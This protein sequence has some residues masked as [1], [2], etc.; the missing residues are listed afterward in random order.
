M[1]IHSSTL[2]WEIPR[3][4]E[5]GGLQSLLLSTREPL[6]SN[7]SCFVSMYVSSDN[8]S[9]SVRQAP[10]LGSWKGSPFWE[11]CDW[12]ARTP[13]RVRLSLGLHQNSQPGVALSPSLSCYSKR[14][15]LWLGFHRAKEK[16]ATGCQLL[17][18]HILLEQHRVLP[19]S[20][21]SGWPFL[22]GQ[23]QEGNWFPPS[24]PII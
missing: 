9:P 20:Y 4:E 16:Q 15:P 5:P 19:H 23:I 1:S 13:C 21:L 17:T 12:H 10:T 18:G 24:V 3:A 8:S 14:L 6:P 2:A 22:G 11:Q 7:V